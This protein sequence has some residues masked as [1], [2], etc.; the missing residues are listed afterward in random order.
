MIPSIGIMIGL[1]ILMRYCEMI[2]NNGMPMKIAIVIIMF[3]TIGIVLTLMTTGI[4][5]LTPN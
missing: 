5:Q 1:Y 3:C 4:P 2:K